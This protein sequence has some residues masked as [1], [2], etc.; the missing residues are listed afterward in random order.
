MGTYIFFFSSHTPNRSATP[1]FARLVKAPAVRSTI[2]F[3]SPCAFRL[4]ALLTVFP[5]PDTTGIIKAPP[6]WGAPS[7]NGENRFNAP[8]RIFFLL[9][10]QQLC[11]LFIAPPRL[12]CN[13]ADV[14]PIPRST[15]CPLRSSNVISIT[16][17]SRCRTGM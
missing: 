5:T 9:L 4:A 16:S 6:Y 13:T 1:R 17:N 15:M 11:P 10:V 3:A 14:T 7:Y 2:R 8:P 12:K